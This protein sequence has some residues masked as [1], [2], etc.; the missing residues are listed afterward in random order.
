MKTKNM[1][2]KVFLLLSFLFLFT[3]Q[4]TAYAA[5]ITGTAIISGNAVYGQT[6]TASVQD[7]DTNVGPYRYQWMREGTPIGALTESATYDLV[8]ADIGYQISVTISSLGDTGSITSEATAAVEKADCE[9]TPIL[10][11]VL[12]TK[13]D[14]TI[15]LD[16]VADYEYIIV[17]AGEATSTGTWQDSNEF[18]GLTHNKSYDVYQR[19]KAT[20]TH[21]ASIDSDKLTVST[22]P[23]ELTGTTNISGSAV[24]GEILTASFVGSHD[25]I[26]SYQWLREGVD[27]TS[28]TNETYTLEEAD[29]NQKISVRA[30]SSIETG[31]VTSAQTAAVEKAASTPAKGITPVFVSA[32]DTTI[33]VSAISG[34]EYKIVAD[35]WDPLS[36]GTWQGSNEFTG[37]TDYTPYDIYQR[38]KETPTHKAS[39]ISDKLDTS[40]SAEV[41]TGTASISGTAVY[42]ATLTAGLTGSN[43]SGTLYYQWMRGA[44]AIASPSELA[45]SY[46]IVEADI[47]KEISL[48]ITSS[49]ETGTLTAGP[50]AAVEKADCEVTPIEAPVL[51]AKTAVSVTVNTVTGYEY[52]IV[53]N[54][55]DATTGKWKYENEFTGLSSNTAYDIYQ[56]VKETSTHKASAVSAKLD[57][58]TEIGGLTGTANIS[59]TLK[60]G[61]ILTATLTASNNTGTLS[62]QWVR[63]S[64]NIPSAIASTY[65]LGLDDIGKHISVKISSS[66]ETGTVTSAQT[67]AVEK[68]D[69]IISVGTTPVLASKTSSTI[70]LQSK[71]GYEYMI[72][73]DGASYTTGSWQASNVFPGLNVGTAY[74]FYQRV[75]ETAT[76]KPSAVSPKLDVTT[77]GVTLTGT[78]YVTG[79]AVYGQTLTAN[80]SASNNTGTLSYQWM[81]GTADIPSATSSTYVLGASDVGQYIKVKIWSSSEAGIITST[82]TS[83]VQKANST[84]SKGVA[85][86]LSDRSRHTITLTARTG[87]EYMLVKNGYSYTT[88]TWKSSNV[89]TDLTSDTYYDVYQRVKETSTHKASAVS[90]KL[91][92]HTRAYTGSS[93]STA[94]PTP[95]AKPSAS[96][97][98]TAT[99]TA[100][101]AP[102]ATPSPSTTPTPVKVT[103]TPVK[104]NED[105]ASGTVTVEIKVSDLPQGT[106]SIKTSDNKVVTVSGTDTVYVTVN[107][108][109]IKEDGTIEFVTLDEEGVA[110]GYMAIDASEVV[111]RPEKSGGGSVWLWVIIGLAAILAFTGVIYVVGRIRMNGRHGY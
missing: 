85:P 40:T 17:V 11:P 48:K 13:T 69:C 80:L 29:I 43:N 96:T 68:A 14:T 38:V 4:I 20:P 10:A 25:G 57:V 79:T 15:V 24:Y 23:S 107:K 3:L 98:P 78:A 39:E 75:T 27:I 102:T 59:G 9:V 58:T 109:D 111:E 106:K 34:Y 42:G 44:D 41:L 22:N 51:S 108:E 63:E 18:T 7:G 61:E 101:P 86:V 16:I 66:A 26:I 71:L 89:F 88:G 90:D 12:S 64:T 76:Q 70:T 67:A 6:L 35:G 56:R 53:E 60:F 83:A 52:K 87:Y 81:R 50:T 55:A 94:T 103:V 99:P 32:T 97:T 110:L 21:K 65:T 77:N 72:V 31:S 33:T 37:L 49:V 104:I 54:G 100:T 30:T 46:E 62:Y 91:D 47:G 93:S 5:D 84:V 8:E 2:F 73:A 82:Q 95:T 1:L 74:D 36:T 28:A 19:V 92:V 105:K 45:T